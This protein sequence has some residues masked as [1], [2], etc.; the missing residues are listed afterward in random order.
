MDVCA[1][2]NTDA[3]TRRWA[4]THCRIAPELLALKDGYTTIDVEMTGSE[5]R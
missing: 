4:V 3:M 2:T 5:R 1:V